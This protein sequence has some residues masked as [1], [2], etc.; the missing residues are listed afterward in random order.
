MMKE[1][2][3]L[4]V[5]RN[6]VLIFIFA[7]L[8]LSGNVF[9][10]NDETGNGELQWADFSNATVTTR[11]NRNNQHE[12][13]IAGIVYHGDGATGMGLQ[14]FLSKNSNVNPELQD[15]N[16]RTGMWEGNNLVFRLSVPTNFE[17]AGNTYLWVRERRGNEYKIHLT[18][19]ELER[20]PINF[21]PLSAFFILS[22]T[23]DRTEIFFLSDSQIGDTGV[24]ERNVNWQIGRI[25]DNSLLIALRDG[26]SNANDRLMTYARNDQNPLGR[27]QAP[28]GQSAGVMRNVNIT[29][30]GM[31]YILLEMDDENGKFHPISMVDI[32]MRKS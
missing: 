29:D 32:A 21:R 10:E 30:R 17:L 12:V 18:A 20:Q 31:Y 26:Q 22:S 25:T 5:M 19:V 15:Q 13:V 16:W 7:M 2:S 14:T 23:I 1:K 27:G 9:A 11:R 8:I 6:I 3:S 4:R 24:N 28:V